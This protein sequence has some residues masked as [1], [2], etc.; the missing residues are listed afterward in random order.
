MG[1]Q[2]SSSALESQRAH[3]AVRAAAAFLENPNNDFHR[4]RV[5]KNIQQ[6]SIH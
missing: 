3:R 2:L 6:R 4:V 1:C 5:L